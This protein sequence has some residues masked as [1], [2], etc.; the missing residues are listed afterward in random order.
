MMA[1]IVSNLVKSNE[2]INRQF[3]GYSKETQVSRIIQEN[4]KLHNR[5]IR[6]TTKEINDSTILI[7][8]HPEQGYWGS[9]NWAS[10]KDDGFSSETINRVINSNN[11]FI[12]TF[13]N[14]VFVNEITTA[15][16]DTTTQKMSFGADEI[17]QSLVVAKN[18]VSYTNCNLSYEGSL[19]NVNA[20]ISFD[21]GTSFNNVSFDT[22]SIF[23]NS[24]TNG[25]VLKMIASSSAAGST[26]YVTK[27]II[28]Y[29]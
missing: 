3:V 12:E 10:S 5:I 11:A 29:D 21:G 2:N 4:I 14:T 22:P 17:Y 27:I 20:L 7:W 24:S 16:I 9:F 6:V 15:T 23:N 18:D 13:N 19:V 1:D 28:N 26:D 8:N 25:I